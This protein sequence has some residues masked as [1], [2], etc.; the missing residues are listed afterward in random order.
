MVHMNAFKL[1]HQI[2]ILIMTCFVTTNILIVIYYFFLPNTL[3]K[4]EQTLYQKNSNGFIPDVKNAN[5]PYDLHD[6]VLNINSYRLNHLLKIIQNKE[7]EFESVM[8]ALNLIQFNKLNKNDSSNNIIDA[9]SFNNL[10][11]A[12]IEKYLD[13][14]PNGVFAKDSLVHELNVLSN[15]YSFKSMHDLFSVNELKQSSNNQNTVIVTI[16]DANS[17]EYLQATL[18][19]LHL[20]LPKYK[21]IVYDLG[22]T[23]IM[24]EKV[25][26]LNYKLFLIFF[27]RN[28]FHV[29]ILL[30]FC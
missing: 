1:C 5:D 26:C 3:Q 17:F 28:I 22:L 11:K 7:D 4:N 13:I 6:Y 18:Y 21:I 9:K 16:S 8:N 27:S 14:E 29:K 30:I 12:E 23:D 19:H 25:S 20:Y 2:R 24:R 10:F 15:N